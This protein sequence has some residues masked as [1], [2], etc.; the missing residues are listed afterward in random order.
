MQRWQQRLNK[1]LG[2]LQ[3]AVAGQVSILVAGEAALPLLGSM[4]HQPLKRVAV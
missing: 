3:E 4:E 2:S 1:V